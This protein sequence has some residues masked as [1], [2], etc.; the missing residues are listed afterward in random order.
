MIEVEPG[1]EPLEYE[2]T[3]KIKYTA[4]EAVSRRIQYSLENAFSGMLY[5]ISRFG[6]SVTEKSFD[7]S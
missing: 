7:Q 3:I 1:A 6:G 2:V 5:D 4:L